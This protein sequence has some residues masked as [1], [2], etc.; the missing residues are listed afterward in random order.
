MMNK[1]DCF[2]LGYISRYVG[3]KGELAFSLDTDS[4][5]RYAN[6]N[7]VFIDI[8]GAL[9]PFF[10][11]KITVKG[12][13]AVASLEGIDTIQKAEELVKQTLYLPLTFLPPLTGKKF[14]FHEMP[15]YKVMDKTHGDIGI[16]DEVLDLPQ[17]AVFQIKQG[18]IEILIPANEQFIVSIN[19]EA[20]E[21]LIDAP[22]GLIDIYLQK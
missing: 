8:N 22:E 6:I 4:P 18:E 13:N 16:I 1:S 2:I 3:L 21:L 19:R 10:I 17:H 5:E 9:V 11:S 20:K 7:T 12:T 14:Y 15:G